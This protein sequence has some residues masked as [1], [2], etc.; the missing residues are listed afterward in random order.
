MNDET[1]N[2]MFETWRPKVLAMLSHYSKRYTIDDEQN[3]LEILVR[4]IELFP[5]I[6][7]K[8]TFYVYLQDKIRWYA[9]NTRRDEPKTIRLGDIDENDISSLND[10]SE[11]YQ[12]S[13]TISVCLASLSI[14]DR[15]IILMHFGLPPFDHAHSCLEIQDKT[16]INDT[17]LHRII[18]KSLLEMRKQVKP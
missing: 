16:G 2:K 17:T 10:G 1:D 4:S 3:I 6:K 13:D 18:N 7:C 9:S 5:T 12:L 11:N 8:K 14:S 15:N